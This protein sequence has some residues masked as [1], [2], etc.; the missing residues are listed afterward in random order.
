MRKCHLNCRY[1]LY[2]SSRQDQAAID[3]A[4]DAVEDLQLKYASLIYV[5]ELADDAKTT[6][7]SSHGDPNTKKVAS[8][9]MY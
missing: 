6:Y 5:A 2:G 9:S 4:V 8:G 7:W 1:K 3:E